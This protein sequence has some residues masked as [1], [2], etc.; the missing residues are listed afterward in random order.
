[1]GPVANSRI[2]NPDPTPSKDPHMPAQ[3]QTYQNHTA[4]D[5]VHTPVLLILLV[6]IL[7]SII[8]ASVAHTP[9][10]PLRMWVVLLS[11]ALF[12]SSLKARTN[13]QRVQD[14][15]IR[16]EERL[17]YQALLTPAEATAALALPLP[18]L[19]ALRFASDAELPTLIHR[20]LAEDLTPKQIKQAITNWRPDTHRV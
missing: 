11:A 18:K 2:I 5:A 15:L 6:N 13:A 20:A 3:P 19:I 17:R 14:R 1:M 9:G 12:V 10:L 8:W 7:V 4:R 16:L